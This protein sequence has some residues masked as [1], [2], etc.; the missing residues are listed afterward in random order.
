MKTPKRMTMIW[1]HDLVLEA[2]ETA[3]KMP[4]SKR[5]DYK[6][7]WPEVK[8]DWFSY[9]SAETEVRLPKATSVQISKYDWIIQRTTELEMK[10]RTLVWATAHSAAFRSRG[11]KW[12]QLARMISVDRRTVKERYIN[13]MVKLLA[14]CKR[15]RKKRGLFH[16]L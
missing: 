5:F 11:P 4:G 6:S 2:A 9:T 3:R 14:I 16:W 10:D 12:S 8:Q 1:L 15:D 13:A 7:N